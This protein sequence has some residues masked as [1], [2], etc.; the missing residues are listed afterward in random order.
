MTYVRTEQTTLLAPYKALIFDLDNTLTATENYHIQALAL[1]LQE[2]LGYNFTYADSQ[3]YIGITCSEMSGRI[4]QRLGR[5][6]CTPQQIA[7]R[8]HQLVMQSF[9]ALPYPGAVEFLRLQQQRRLL[10]IGSNS[11]RE[12]VLSCLQGCDILACFAQIV[13][14]DEVTKPKPAADIFLK[15]AELLGVCPSECLV[16]EDS[17]TGLAAAQAAGVSAVLVLNPGNPLPD[18]LPTNTAMLTW[19]Q[20]LACG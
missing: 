8:K 5:T 18:P 15:A 7:Q 19:S 11:R 2:F 9:Q 20:L 3:E 10:A 1:A 12:F 14:R 16:F 4:L 17:A 6:D 13:S